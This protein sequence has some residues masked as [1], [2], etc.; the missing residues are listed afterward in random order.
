M[1]DDMPQAVGR[2]GADRK[3][4]ERIRVSTVLGRLAADKARDRIS[5]GDL[6]AAMGDR[7]F[8]ALMLIFAL[9][10]ILPTLPG[11]SAITGAP[12]VVL[13]AQMTFGLRPWLPKVI[14]NRSMA[15]ADFAAIVNSLMPWLLRAEHFLRPRLSLLARPPAEY[16]VGS[17]CLILAVVLFLPM[18][19]GNILPALAISLAA[20]GILERDGLWVIAS[21]ACAA[22]AL[23]VV[24]SATFA[25]ALTILLLIGGDLP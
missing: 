18:P 16:L 25:V 1:I 20:F 19:L 24:G 3:G 7:A 13:A 8:G 2:R 11:T 22:V 6:L 21:L 10:N 5:V 15:T 12:L 23:A 9:P 14:A 4:E 17:V